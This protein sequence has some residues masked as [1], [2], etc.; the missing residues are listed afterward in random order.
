MAE[1]KKKPI[2]SPGV[3]SQGPRPGPVPP[4]R[5]DWIPRV[6]PPPG[7]ETAPEAPRLLAGAPVRKKLL[8]LPGV[9]VGCRLCELA[10]SLNHEGMINPY[11]AR[12]KVTQIREAGVAEPTICRHCRPAP[13]E[14]ACP[15]EALSPSPELPEVV[16]WDRD[17]CIQCHKCVDACPFGALHI[18][19]Q[20][21]ILKC[22]L[23]GGSPACA[24]VC[25]DRPEF[26]PPHWLGG[27]LSA[28]A[29]IAPQDAGRLK[30]L[31]RLK[32]P[33]PE[34]NKGD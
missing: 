27:K 13:C 29:F 23:C 32:G 30:R 6:V 25:Q 12:I 15:N 24:A 10:C 5:P 28:L 7:G 33:R 11:L 22:D 19:P 26:R 4:P 18:G 8:V 3:N 14:E 9:C 2:P 1:K 16:I 21:D 31:L 20:G 17:K 34:K